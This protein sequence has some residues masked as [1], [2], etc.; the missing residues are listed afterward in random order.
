MTPLDEV[1]SEG[2]DLYFPA[3]LADARS[4]PDISAAVENALEALRGGA[5]SWARM[6]QVMHLCSQAGM[7]EGFY[8]Y[9]F[10]RVPS[11]HPYPVIRV[12]PGGEY[13]P[14]SDSVEIGSMKQFKWGVQRFIYDAMLYWGNFVQAYRDLRQSSEEEIAEYFGSKRINAERLT[15]RGKVVDP[16]PIPQDHR[17]LISEMA[18][19]TYD[20]VGAIE[21]ADHVRIALTAFR[22]L[23]AGSGDQPISPGALRDR[24]TTL[25][26]AQGQ[27]ALFEL[28]REDPDRQLSSEEEVIALY[29]PQFEISKRVRDIALKNTRTYLSICSDLDVYVATSMR[30]R[31]DFR[32]MA[33]ISES[34]FQSERLKQYNIRYFDPTLSAANFHEDKGIIECLMVKTCK[35]LVYFAQHK[36]SLGKISE[37][38]MALSLGKPVII[39]CPS[40]AK[41]TEN[42]RFYQERHPLTRLIE[43]ETGIVTGAMITQSLDDV[44]ELIGR[45]FSNSMEYDLNKKP[46]TSAYYLLRERLTQST[47]RVVTED[48]LL[49]ETF[50]NN[51]HRIF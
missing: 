11:T 20:H 12:L 37:Y 2:L 6:N 24:A 33:R 25:A 47:V 35:V 49:T 7:S 10:L 15:R 3:L 45:I 1:T 8:S 4:N 50:W 38:A 23:K 31:E 41:G 22:E 29:S 30:T 39:L 40:D 34:L 48:R 5:L 28:L 51:Y 14:P 19:K 9:Y 42:Y 18:C 36:E 44:V 21:N 32:E 17:Y 26:D 43:F 13:R 46:G 16:V 27:L